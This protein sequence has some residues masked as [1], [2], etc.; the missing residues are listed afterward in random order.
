MVAIN[1]FVA[2]ELLLNCSE[3]MPAAPELRPRNN[4]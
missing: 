1:D 4:F 2:R 3:S